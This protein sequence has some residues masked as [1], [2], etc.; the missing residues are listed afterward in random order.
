MSELNQVLPPPLTPEELRANTKYWSWGCGGHVVV[1]DSTGGFPVYRVD[2]VVPGE[3][4]HWLPHRAIKIR[5]NQQRFDPEITETFFGW[6]REE[7]QGSNYLTHYLREVDG[8][9]L[10]R[11]PKGDFAHMLDVSRLLASPAFMS[12][13]F[14]HDKD[15]KFVGWVDMVFHS[16]QFSVEERYY[17]F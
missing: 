7:I 15:M 8:P 13:L 9:G 12:E 10:I 5:K 16:L 1:P 3:A 14:L 4:N 17:W 6:K 11:I 2:P